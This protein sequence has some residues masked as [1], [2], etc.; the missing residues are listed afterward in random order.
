MPALYRR[1][2][3]CYC[4]TLA[5]RPWTTQAATSALLWCVPVRMRAATSNVL[6]GRGAG[7]VAAQRLERQTAEEPAGGADLR[8]VGLVTLYGGAFIGPLGHA[9]LEALE[10]GTRRAG[11]ASGSPRAIA[12]KLVADTMLFGPVHVASFFGL[13]G[14]VSGEST[15][16]VSQ[17]L[18]DKF[19]PTLLAESVGWPAVQA[20]NFAYVPVQHQL[21]VVNVVSLLDCTFLSWVKHHDLGSG[22]LQGAGPFGP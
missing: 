3:K 16:V 2:V 10:L 22:L 8:R 19:W 21:L 7:D 14:V 15:A 12:A 4:D 11:L 18:R 9:W 5:A 6:R 20:V 1:L 17:R 13:M